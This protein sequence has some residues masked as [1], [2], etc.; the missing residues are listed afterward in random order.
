MIDFKKG[1][2]LLAIIGLS[3]CANE[4]KKTAGQR[5]KPANPS[6]KIDN[7]NEKPQ[8][9]LSDEE[10]Q[11]KGKTIVKSTMGALKTQLSQAIAKGGA[12]NAIRFCKVHAMPITDSLSE[13]YGAR[14]A[15]VSDRNRN[16]QNAASDREE[17]IIE[18][19]RGSMQAGQQPKPMVVETGDKV[20][21]YH[22]ISIKSGLCLNCHGTP[23]EE[24]NQKTMA[25]IE[26]RY[27]HDQ[28]KGYAMNDLRGLW[29]VQFAKNA[30]SSPKP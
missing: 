13:V 14:V 4:K 1:I 30:P 29:K 2:V 22:P 8:S 7:A 24:I 26:E 16:P 21:Y 19:M 5:E 17:A 23:G 9:G 18:N 27:P 11:K 3:A 15:R 10:Y 20:V 6:E 28:A 25:A 12:P